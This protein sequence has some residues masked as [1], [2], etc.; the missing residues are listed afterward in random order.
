MLKTNGLLSCFSY[1][2]VSFKT[3]RMKYS[4][5]FSLV[6]GLFFMPLSAQNERKIT[7]LPFRSPKVVKKAKPLPQNRRN[8]Q[9][10]RDTLDR[11]YMEKEDTVKDYLN[12]HNRMK[13][14]PSSSSTAFM[15]TVPG[16]VAGERSRYRKGETES[17]TRNIPFTFRPEDKF[18]GD[19]RNQ[20][21]GTPMA[22]GDK[23]RAAMSLSV[24]M[25]RVLAMAFSK[26][27]RLRA[28]NEKNRLWEKYGKVVPN[29]SLAEA[30]NSRPK[31][32]LSEK[33]QRE[34]MAAKNDSIFRAA[35]ESLR[36]PG[37]QKN[38]SRGVVP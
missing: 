13:M 16:F 2:C 32:M 14:A 24:D 33:Q 38:G 18:N 1:F 23:G 30:L 6:F 17:S 29:D 15:A 34:R 9:E 3:Y 22:G 8:R 36:M 21:A 37:R 10:R 26:N 28:R 35:T 5:L 19:P 12:E 7:I 20:P 4:L 31:E 27:A 25:N 11:A